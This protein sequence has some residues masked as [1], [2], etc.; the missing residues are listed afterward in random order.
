[1]K[2]FNEVKFLLS[3]SPSFSLKIP[4]KIGIFYIVNKFKDILK[5][6][7][8][9]RAQIRITCKGLSSVAS[10]LIMQIFCLKDIMG[11]IN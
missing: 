1:M 8:G 11:S 6:K 9:G 2:L 4:C 3:L 5:T 7:L 10:L